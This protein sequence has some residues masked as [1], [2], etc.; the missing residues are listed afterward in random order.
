MNTQRRRL[1]F[2]LLITLGG[3]LLLPRR[4]RSQAPLDT[5]EIDRFIASQMAAQRI[6]GLALAV[7]Q[8][9]QVTY[10]QGY[11]TPAAESAGDAADAIPHRLPQQ[12]LHRHRR[13]AAG[14]GREARPRCARRPLPA[15][16]H[17]GRPRRGAADHRAAAAQPHQRA[18]RRRDPRPAPRAAGDDGRPHHHPARRPP[19]RPA[20]HASSTTPT[21]TTRSWP[22]SSRRRAG[23]PSRTTCRPTSLRRCR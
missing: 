11:G 14:G 22:A 12:I 6:P 15:R 3:I 10:L 8:G 13:A 20:R 19:R 2:I 4:G 1:L 21:P 7:I 18:G 16:L 9:D 5:A 17:P 23:S